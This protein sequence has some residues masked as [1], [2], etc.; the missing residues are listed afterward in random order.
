MNTNRAIADIDIKKNPNVDDSIKPDY[1]VLYMNKS[2]LE[3]ST[4]TFFTY[5]NGAQIIRSV[6]K[7]LYPECEILKIK[8]ATLN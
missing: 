4:C 8:A 5:E 1:K 6:F 7:T 3:I 2:T